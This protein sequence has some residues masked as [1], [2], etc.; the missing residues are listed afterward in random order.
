MDILDIY[1]SMLRYAGLEA[2]DNGYISTVIAMERKDPTLVNGARLVLPTRNQLQQFDTKEKIIFH[3]LLENIVHGESPVI[4]KLTDCI[5]DK[6]NYTI[7]AVAASLLN[8]LASP[9]LHAKL[10]P[11]QAELL[12]SVKDVDEKCVANFMNTMLHGMKN[13]SDRYFT[14]IYLK[15]R[16]HKGK[17]IF[18]RMAVVS[19]P[20]Y[21]GIDDNSK[22]RLKDK[23]A[24][25]ELFE[26]MFPSI[27]EP[28]FY[29]YGSNSRIA[30]CIDAL[31][32][33]SIGIASALNDMMNTYGDYIEDSDVMK[34]D[35]YWVDYFNNLEELRSE[36]RK[37]P[38]HVGMDGGHTPAGEP[39][40]ETVAPSLLQPVQSMPAVVPSAAIVPGIAPAVRTPQLMKTER[41]LD[42]HSIV[43]TT[44]AVAATPNPLP[45]PG[46]QLM[47]PWGNQM[48]MGGFQQP[49]QHVPMFAGGSG[50]QYPGQYPVSNPQYPYGYTA[51]PII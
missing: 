3:P 17:E 34:F 46:Q 11:E 35:D 10:S 38:L 25:K 19:F 18:S 5:N 13:K 16:G 6:L 8:L 14:N 12:T 49:Q 22:I 47:N 26:F 45:I 21:D 43:A 39:V 36:I 7:G 28:D 48:P 4:A 20:F 30:P 37:I 24:Y 44:P 23:Q 42:F 40:V 33:S 31:M 29:N 41:G 2:D 50:V 9:A 1:R 32:M 15:R 27:K 51:G